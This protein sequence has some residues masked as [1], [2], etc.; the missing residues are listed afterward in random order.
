MVYLG[1][2]L[3][4]GYFLGNRFPG[5]KNYL[6]YILPASVIILLIPVFLQIRKNKQKKAVK[7]RPAGNRA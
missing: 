1:L 5:I 2:F 7:Q 4:A 3:F 6:G